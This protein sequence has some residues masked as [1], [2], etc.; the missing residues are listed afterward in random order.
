MADVEEGAKKYK[1]RWA[2]RLAKETE[3]ED[4]KRMRKKNKSNYEPYVPFEAMYLDDEKE[5]L[6]DDYRA[7]LSA[8]NLF[9]WNKKTDFYTI[10]KNE[11]K[12]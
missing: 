10:K 12:S 6:N 1:G 8:L 11:K 4:M 5:N 9:R 2:V 7:F 3:V